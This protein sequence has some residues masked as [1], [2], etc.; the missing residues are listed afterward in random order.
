MKKLIA[1]ALSIALSLP[2]AACGK[3]NEASTPET[4]DNTVST[5][6]SNE[7]RTITDLGGN[8]VE[9]PA[10]S[11]IKRV[12]I[13]APPVMSFVLGT[14]PDSKMI[15]GINARAFTTSNK[16]IVSKVFPDWKSVNTT[17]IDAS[18]VVNKE[19]L[20]KLN[21][22][23]IFY[24][25]NVQKQGLGN[26]GI[27][28]VDFFSKELKGPE[29][30]SIASDNLLREIF[31][32]ESSNNQQQEWQRTNKKVA[33]LLASKGE[34]KSA[35]CVFSNAAGKI[36]VSGKDSFDAYAQSYLDMAGIRNVADDLKGATEVSM[37]KIYEWNP[38]MII[39]FH[40]APAKSILNNTIDGQD[41]SLLDAW[42][43]KAVYDI[44]RTTFSWIT[45]CADAPLM[46][47][48]LV[49]KAYP[50][51]LGDGEMRTEI[52][53]YYQRNY[54]ISLTGHELDSILDYRE[55]SGL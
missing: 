7:M 40:N 17:F 41:W 16:D 4:S 52:A 36:V 6:Q 38:D 25:G 5:Q 15:V 18:F 53:D 3:T 10:S 55:A 39:V 22:D 11:A 37:E 51:L 45:P 21:P 30:F 50:E 31:E 35:L 44:P 46:P 32:L 43:N 19:S 13:I 54:K 24:Y 26:V 48:W 14:I 1:L 12:V 2:L 20:L 34:M 28:S 49:S 23:I 42:K 29:A 33:E 9:I 47:F 8:E 27:P